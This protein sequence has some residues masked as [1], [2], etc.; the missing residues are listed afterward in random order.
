[1]N[2]SK[3][4]SAEHELMWFDVAKKAKEALLDVLGDLEVSN[5]VAVICM[6]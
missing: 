4:A 5:K 1:M 6:G 3:A 2:A